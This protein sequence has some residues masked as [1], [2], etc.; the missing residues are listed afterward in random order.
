MASKK[1]HSKLIDKLEAIKTLA[2]ES[3]VLLRAQSGSP[4]AERPGGRTWRSCWRS[5]RPRLG[6][7]RP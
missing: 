1:A 2:E 6:C 3:A 5:C 4:D 7:N